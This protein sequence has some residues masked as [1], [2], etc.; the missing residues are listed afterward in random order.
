MFSFYFEA[1]GAFRVT[2]VTSVF[3]KSFIMSE[4][5]LRKFLMM[6][7]T[8]SKKGSDDA[9]VIHEEIYDDGKDII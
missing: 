7:V 9:K 3:K 1:I 5:Y 8:Y 6:V 2:S 4:T